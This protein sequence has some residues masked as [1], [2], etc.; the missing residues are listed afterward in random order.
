MRLDT[1]A[2]VSGLFVPSSAVK[3][4]CAILT[5]TLA[6]L[7]HIAAQKLLPED[8]QQ[9][10]PLVHH[11]KPR[12][13]SMLGDIQSQ[14]TEPDAIAG[15]LQMEATT[16]SPLHDLPSAD[17]EIAGEERDAQSCDRHIHLD[18]SGPA[19]GGQRAAGSR[20]YE[21]EEDT[22]SIVDEAGPGYP[23]PASTIVSVPLDAKPDLSESD[24]TLNSPE[25]TEAL[26][27]SFAYKKRKIELDD[28]ELEDLRVFAGKAA[29]EELARPSAWTAVHGEE[30]PEEGG[31]TGAKRSGIK[32]CSG[33]FNTI[34]NPFYHPRYYNGKKKVVLR[35][36][37]KVPG[38]EG[39][40]DGEDGSSCS[41]E[42]SGRSLASSAAAS[43]A[44]VALLDNIRCNTH[45][46]G[47]HRD[48]RVLVLPH[49]KHGDLGERIRSPAEGVDAA[50]WPPGDC[51]DCALKLL[52][53]GAESL[54]A[55]GEGNV[56]FHGDIK[57]I[58]NYI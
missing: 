26:A 34:S 36:L 2:N 48:Q 8:V 14:G 43:K 58:N 21:K 16:T 40:A 1:T 20:A 29:A 51:M 57:V 4:P 47:F 45:I 55:Q 19:L 46:L 6:L 17:Q 13:L 42:I 11:S 18:H 37:K 44:F 31:N 54:L 41:N 28:D 22:N 52:K 38:K 30:L 49:F 53:G 3:P 56:F 7:S 27:E 10:P 32:A 15:P 39:A 33:T 50:S 35:T 12:S 24:L 23:I 25:G 9:E 5:A